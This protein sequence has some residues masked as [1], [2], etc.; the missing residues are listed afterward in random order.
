MGSQTFD[1]LTESLLFNNQLIKTSFSSISEKRLQEELNKYRE[2]C[3]SKQS[4]LQLEVLSYQS[5]LKV[6]SGFKMPPFSLLKQSALYI[7]QYVI[8]DPIFSFGY[9]TNQF[10]KALGSYLGVENKFSKQGLVERIK[11]VKALTPMIATNY[12]KLL[13]ISF[14]LEPPEQIPI[15]YP[16]NQLSDIL[17]ESIIE[18]FH[19]NLIIK[20]VKRLPEPP[21]A[22][23][24]R[25]LELSREIFISFKD[26]LKNE[27][28]GYTLFENREFRLLDESTGEF[29]AVMHVPDE[30]PELDCFNNWISQSFNSSCKEFYNTIVW[31]NIVANK[32]EASYLAESP[33]VFNLLTQIFPSDNQIDI[34]AANTILNMELP[35]MD[36]ID[37]STLMEIRMNDGEEFQNFRLHLEKQFKD[38]RLIKDP[39]ELKIKAENA[40]H[41][42]SDVQVHVVNQKMNQIK[43]KSYVVDAV[44]LLG[45]LVSAIQSGGMSIPALSVAAAARG[46]KPFIDGS[47]QIRQNPA[48]FLWKVLNKSSQKLTNERS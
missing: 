19:E 10:S 45:S 30:P 31:K 29:E 8:D 21:G 44:I 40:M 47:N 6:F 20:S 2:F 42:L 38:L 46:V 48:F 39:E 16:E 23:Q 18:F 26:H 25:D 27:A 14:F 37:V 5:N 32:F 12:I 9:Q 41:E 33:F 34:N 4:E 15:L 13:P 1:F 24:L 43:N 7:N 35:F 17:P 11:Y 36:Q 3:L 28:F 22:I